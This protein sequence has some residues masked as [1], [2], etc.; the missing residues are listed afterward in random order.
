MQMERS[1]KAERIFPHCRMISFMIFDDHFTFGQWNGETNKRKKEV[2]SQCTWALLYVLSPKQVQVLHLYSTCKQHIGVDKN[3]NRNEYL[4]EYPSQR[5]KDPCLF[6]EFSRACLRFPATVNV[7]CNPPNVKVHVCRRKINAT[8]SAV[9]YESL[10]TP[11]SLEQSHL[12][13]LLGWRAELHA[14]IGWR[15]AE[16][17]CDDASTNEDFAS[18]LLRSVK[19]LS[20]MENT[21]IG[22]IIDIREAF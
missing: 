10:D 22:E 3:V 16:Q 9:W 12:I 13:K 6:L 1:E 5:N 2:S 11:V 4:N 8:M 19:C 7:M 21:I 20:C 18:T 17:T 14:E 15:R